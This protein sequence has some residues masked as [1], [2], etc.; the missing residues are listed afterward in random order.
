MSAISPVAYND[1]PE[2]IVVVAK[3]LEIC[4]KRYNFDLSGAIKFGM[5]S[6]IMGG[7]SRVSYTSTLAQ[8]LGDGLFKLIISLFWKISS[9]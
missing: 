1:K 5:Y 6:R 2:F 9:P 3:R 4:L 7:I 8:A